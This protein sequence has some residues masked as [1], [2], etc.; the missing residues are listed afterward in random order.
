MTELEFQFKTELEFSAPVAEHVF[1][2]HCLPYEDGVQAAQAFG[3]RLEP[4]AGYELRRDGF[5]GWLVCGAC[6][7]PHKK[8]AYISHGIARVDLSRRTPAAVNPVL[9]YPTALTRPERAVRELW[10]GLPLEGRPAR[11]QAETLNLAAAAALKYTQGVTTN[12][13]SAAAAL[14]LG[15]G[16]CQDYAH[17]LLA[18]ARLSGFAARYCMGL[19]PG[20]GATH[21]WAELALPEG[22]IGYDPTHARE[23]GESYLR[24]AVGRDAAD[25][26]AERGT[27]KGIAQQSMRVDMTLRQRVL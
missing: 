21:A 27:F 8:F 20:E 11:E 18:L 23:A 7:E 25:C 1:A 22:W 9:R 15:Q 5:G 10:Q 13:T 26:R 4:A 3:V 2:L 17:L 6:R 24:F 12:A 14:E 19:I 16:V